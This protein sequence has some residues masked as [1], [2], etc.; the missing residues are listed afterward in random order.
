M[1]ILVLLFGPEFTVTVG[2]EF[3]FII[4]ILSFSKIFRKDARA[5]GAITRIFMNF[6]EELV[7]DAR[8]VGWFGVLIIMRLMFLIQRTSGEL[9]YRLN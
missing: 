7:F 8:E 2:L 3:F 9:F 4:W 1:L 5:E 6:T